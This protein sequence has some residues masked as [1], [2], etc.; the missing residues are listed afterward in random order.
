MD[1]KNSHA[2]DRVDYQEH[3][4]DLTEVHAA[5]QRE[6]PEP[7]AES[8]PVPMW[9]IATCG[10][11]VCWAGLYLGIFSG[12]FKG[13]VFNELSTSAGALFPAPT[14]EVANAG[15]VA[16]D[17]LALGKSVYGA[18]CAACH[19][20]NGSGQGAAIPPL[21]ASE[22]VTGSEKRLA[23]ILLKGIQG[24]LTVKGA[25]FNGVMPA[26][27][28]SLNNKKIAAVMTYIRANWGNSAPAVSEAKLAAARTEYA[29]RTATMTEADL[30][31]IPEDATLPDSGGGAAPAAGAAAAAGGA[32]PAPTNA[33]AP[34]PAAAAPAP[35]NA[36]PAGNAAA[37][38]A[39]AGNTSPPAAAGAPAGGATA[40]AAAPATPEQI[41]AG[42][43][44]YMTCMPCHQATGAGLPPVFPPLTKSP[45]V[46]GSAERFIAM[47]LK[48][49]V[50][51]MTID[52]KP[53]NNVMPPQEATLDDKKIADVTTYVRNSFGNSAPAITA[54]QVGAARAK[55]TERKT[56][57]TQPEL[58]AWK[59]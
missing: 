29:S 24:P 46:N 45:Y 11:A 34:A 33:A 5:I 55:F 17:P 27:E 9:L 18:N 25:A 19:Q 2:P 20:P 4:G 36:A 59:E 58:D 10:V 50:G 23:A 21:V 48:G 30:K 12:A 40:P 31:A 54:E 49:N 37:P 13:D 43:T 15:P 44:V 56:G 38:A 32:A 22:W 47:V 6:H 57:W 53:Y 35:A 3:A 14:K 42:K 41:A 28:G 51:P 16:E 26:W 1:P 52:G 7:T 8:T 39:P